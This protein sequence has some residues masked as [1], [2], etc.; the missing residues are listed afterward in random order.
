MAELANL[1]QIRPDGIL[2][3]AF[4]ITRN[5]I[6]SIR[7]M[8]LFISTSH[9]KALSIMVYGSCSEYDAVPATYNRLVEAAFN[10]TELKKV[11]F[12]VI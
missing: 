8:V 4:S 10:T 1:F 5:Q 7:W 3:N 2:F 11:D 12:I 6:N 9:S